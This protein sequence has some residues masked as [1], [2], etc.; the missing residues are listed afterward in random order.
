M[1]KKDEVTA[2][3]QVNTYPL[4]I[5]RKECR[6]LFDVSTSTFDGATYGL[7]QSQKYTVEEMKSTIE[8]WK[9]RKV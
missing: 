1:S 9:G 7:D 5:L 2:E 8:K 6:K 3:K 4:S